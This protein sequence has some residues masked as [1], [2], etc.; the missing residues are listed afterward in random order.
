MMQTYV[1]PAVNPPMAQYVPPLVPSPP[2]MPS[3]PDLM[4]S[5]I[6]ASEGLLQG[7]FEPPLP[8]YSSP[9][10]QQGY[11]YSPSVMAKL[12]QQRRSPQVESMA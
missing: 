11:N 1:P 7:G 5:P 9:P 12:L 10:S 8:M 6:S 3:P 4:P 2:L